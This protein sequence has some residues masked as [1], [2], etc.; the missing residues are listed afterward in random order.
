MSFLNRLRLARLTPKAIKRFGRNEDGATAVEFAL[1]SVPFL[2]LLFAIFET[3]YVFFATES[4]ESAVA[5]AGRGIM[6]GNAYAGGYANADAFRDAV[7]CKGAAQI[8][9]TTIYCKDVMVDVRTATTFANADTSDLAVTGTSGGTSNFTM[10]SQQYCVGTTGSIIIM[11]AIYPMRAYL[12]LV[13][14]ANIKTVTTSRDGQTSV[15]G[16]WYHMIDVST[17]FRNE[18]FANQPI[19]TG[20]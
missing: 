14:A 7:I 19:A 17:V 20:C 10:A 11:R 18:P 1:V 2:G 12:S 15:G 4:L 6:T 8:P 16:V 13:T 3:A 9:N 5:D